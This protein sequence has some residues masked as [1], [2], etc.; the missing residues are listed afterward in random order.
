MA[1]FGSW[2]RAQG[3]VQVRRKEG[4]RLGEEGWGRAGLVGTCCVACPCPRCGPL[5]CPGHRDETVPGPCSWA[6]P[7]YPRSCSGCQWGPPCHGGG[8]RPRARQPVSGQGPWRPLGTGPCAPHARRWGAA[9][10]LSQPQHPFRHLRRRSTPP[11]VVAQ[12]WTASSAAADGRP[13]R[14]SVRKCSQ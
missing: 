14:A 1:G 11:G 4:R 8:P 2:S 9:A 10:A 7:S 13:C 3:W 6:V 12:T 5:A